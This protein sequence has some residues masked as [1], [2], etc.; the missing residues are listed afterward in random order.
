MGGPPL[1]I[2]PPGILGGPDIPIGGPWLDDDDDDEDE[3]LG[4]LAWG[5]IM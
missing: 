4:L 3:S 2:G 5:P 1:G